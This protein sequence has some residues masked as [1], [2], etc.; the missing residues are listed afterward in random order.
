MQL[1]ADKTKIMCFLFQK[2]HK[3]A[4]R[5]NDQGKLMAALFGQRHS[6][7][8]PCT[9]TTPTPQSGLIVTQDMYPH[10]CKK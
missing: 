6:T 5:K 9:Q 2:P 4:M 10:S 7:S 8:S 3:P 1:N